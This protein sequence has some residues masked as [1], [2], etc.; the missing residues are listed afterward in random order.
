MQVKQWQKAV[1]KKEKQTKVVNPVKAPR[2]E[3]EVRKKKLLCLKLYLN[4]FSRKHFPSNK[5]K[6]LMIKKKNINISLIKMV[7]TKYHENSY[8]H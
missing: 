2:Q 8:V 7:A 4:Y 3:G 6:I 5:K 1:A